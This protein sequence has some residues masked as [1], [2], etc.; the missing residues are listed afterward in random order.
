MWRA[1]PG[2]A[3]GGALG[4]I[5]SHCPEERAQQQRQ[6]A[7]AADQITHGGLITLPEGLHPGKRSLSAPVHLF[8]PEESHTWALSPSELKHFLQKM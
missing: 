4:G 2:G 6:R 1:G 8:R 3:L 5:P 7:R